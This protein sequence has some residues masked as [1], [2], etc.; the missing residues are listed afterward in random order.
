MTQLSMARYD[1]AGGAIG[2]KVFF[3][4]GLDVPNLF[5]LVDI[6]DIATH[7][8]STASLSEARFTNYVDVINVTTIRHKIFFAGGQNC[9][10]Q[11]CPSNRIDTYDAITNTWS[12]ENYT[13]QDGVLLAGLAAGNKNYWVTGDY[14]QG[15]NL[16]EIRDEITHASSYECLSG[17]LYG[18]PIS[19]GNKIIF[20]VST[21][22]MWTTGFTLT[23][24]D[25]YDLTTNTWSIR[26]VPSTGVVIRNFL[27]VNS[28]VYG[29]GGI[30]SAHGGV[31]YSKIYKLEF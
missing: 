12:N 8:W 25:I 1:F 19:N 18:N 23:H 22:P 24:F 2:N 31:L 29:I 7:S 13:P 11:D 26:N 30:S 6:Y 21:E 3:A 14:W 27:S 17:N 10:I 4:G 28:I 15:G 5:N 16:V 20:P 9:W